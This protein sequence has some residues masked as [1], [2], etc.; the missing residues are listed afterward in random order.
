MMAVENPDIVRVIVYLDKQCNGAAAT[1]LGILETADF[2]SFNNLANKGRFRI[3]HD[4]NVDLNYAAMGGNGTTHDTLG[5]NHSYQWYKSVNIPIEFDNSAD[6]GT[7]A[8]I[9]TNNIGVMLVGVNGT[10]GFG[11]KMRLRFTDN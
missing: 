3:L 2:Q 4:N 5:V 6:D 11:S 7:L 8:T 9:R 1:V 10:A